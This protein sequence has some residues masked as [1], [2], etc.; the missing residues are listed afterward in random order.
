MMPEMQTVD[1]TNIEAIGYDPD[2][3]ELHVRFV[4]SGDTYAYYNVDKWVFNEF[5]AADS[6]GQYLNANIKGV[7]DYARL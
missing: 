1:S 7:Y 2:S 4:Q 5:I 3:R 6:K